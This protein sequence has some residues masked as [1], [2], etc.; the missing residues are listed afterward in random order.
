MYMYSLTKS[1]LAVDFYFQSDA[2]YRL[3]DMHGPILKFQVQVLTLRHP[4]EIFGCRYFFAPDVCDYFKCI[5]TL[6][7]IVLY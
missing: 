2:L 4:I 3:Y 1:F 5:L 6:F 7:V